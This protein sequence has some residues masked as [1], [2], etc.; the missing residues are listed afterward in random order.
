MIAKY[1][2]EGGDNIF[3][4]SNGDSVGDGLGLAISAGAGTS[5]GMNTLYGRLLA[6]SVR[7]EDFNSR[8][9]CLWIN[10]VSDPSLILRVVQDAN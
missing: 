10:I 3:V 8:T 5:R 7:A 2:G 6:A 9:I 1:L 4:R